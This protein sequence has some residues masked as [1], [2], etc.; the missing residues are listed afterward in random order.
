MHADIARADRSKQRVGQGV[1]TDIGVGVAG[2]GMV[3]WDFDAA[4][5][6]MVA[7]GKRVH[8]E[9]LPDAHIAAPRRD[10]P[11]GGSEILCRRY[12]EIV[13]TAGDEQ[14]RHSRRLRHRGV[15]G[16]VSPRRGA[17]RSEDR[18]EVKALGRLR[19]P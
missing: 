7:G 4:K 16:Q 19:T 14:R 1:E 5:A 12:F 10:Q 6:N 15:V 13:F 8:V 11:L 18:V 9:A 3:M 17:M 2:E